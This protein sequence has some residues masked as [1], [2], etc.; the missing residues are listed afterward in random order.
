MLSA[1]N[2]A[3]ANAN[4]YRPLQGYG[5]LNLATNNLYQNYN[6]LQVS[7]IRHAGLYV[8]QANYTWQKAMGII[9]PNIEPFNLAAN[10]GALPADRRNL[11]NAAYSFDLGK[12]RSLQF[13]GERIGATVGSSPASR[14][15]KAA[16][17]LPTA[18]TVQ[19]QCAKR[20]LQHG[21]DLRSDGR[22]N[23]AGLSARNRLRSSRARS[24]LRTRRASRSTTNPSWE[25][26]DQTVEPDS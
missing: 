26:A 4:L 25:R 7:W 11:F 1:T 20:N 10:Y 21:V 13:P 22:G 5:N 6:A 19:Q 14:S 15:W 3:T 9:S 16:P 2:P 23:A 8:I 12:R 17:I 18:A 24:A